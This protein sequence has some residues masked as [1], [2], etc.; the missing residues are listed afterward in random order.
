MLPKGVLIP[1]FGS[2]THSTFSLMTSISSS[3]SKSSNSR[4]LPTGVPPSGPSGR[5]SDPPPP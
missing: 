4:I 3:L 1:S 5:T 2:S